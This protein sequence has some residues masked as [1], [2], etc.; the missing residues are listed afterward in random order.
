[1]M[2]NKYSLPTILM[3]TLIAGSAQATVLINDNY[4]GGS[5]DTEFGF[6]LVA[7]PND[8]IGTEATFDI[9]TMSQPITDLPIMAA[10][11]IES[12]MS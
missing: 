6:G 5:Y 9:S 12:L 4:Y 10:S 3:L 7:E 11:N 8:I 2:M 1:M